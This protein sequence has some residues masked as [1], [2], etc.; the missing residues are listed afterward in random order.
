MTNWQHD[1]K[2]SKLSTRKD[3]NRRYFL[4]SKL[5]SRGGGDDK[6]KNQSNQDPRS[7][8]YPYSPFDSINDVTNSRDAHKLKK[9]YRNPFKD[10]N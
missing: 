9:I 6:N 5:S 2:E 10:V 1:F 8:N 7:G 4:K 3:N